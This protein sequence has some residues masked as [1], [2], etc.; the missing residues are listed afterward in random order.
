METLFVVKRRRVVFTEGNSATPLV[1]IE[2]NGYCKRRFLL[3]SER[4][5][6]SNERDWGLERAR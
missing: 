1:P 3:Y 6:I 5:T 4:E 2:L